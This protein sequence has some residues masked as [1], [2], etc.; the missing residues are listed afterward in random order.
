MVPR[1]AVL[2]LALVVGGA[3]ATG[4]GGCSALGLPGGEG[5]TDG[6]TSGNLRE[7]GAPGAQ[8]TGWQCASDPTTHVELCT[9]V[10]VCP[11]VVVDHDVFPN[12]GFRLRGGI[13]FDLACWCDGWVCP[14]GAVSTCNEAQQALGSQS[15]LQICVQVQEGRCTRPQGGATTGATGTTGAVQP[16]G[17]QECVRAC[18]GS[19]ACRSACGC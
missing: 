1:S 5:G 16:T 12:C 3:L 7:A 8:A 17:C 10:S 6:G 14:M 18:G 2:A 4:A 11:D 9:A 13:T 15:E 19:A